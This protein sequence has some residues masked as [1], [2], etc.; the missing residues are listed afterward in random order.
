MTTHEAG[1]WARRSRWGKV[2]LV[3]SL[4]VIAF[5]AL[6]AILTAVQGEPDRSPDTPA[7]FST[8]SETTASLTPTPV[9]SM[10]EP[11]PLPPLPEPPEPRGSESEPESTE[12]ELES[13]EP[14]PPPPAS[15]AVAYYENCDAARAAG[16]APLF[17]GE[18]GYREALDRDGDG[19]A[20]D[21]YVEP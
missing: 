11:P 13:T 5:F 14:E 16:A 10:P 1:W 8:P 21:P 6:G 7:P 20:C 15:S 2:G 3:A 9:S 17:R 19:M 4:A 12:P 18:P